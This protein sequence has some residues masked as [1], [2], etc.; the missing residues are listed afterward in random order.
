MTQRTFQ[1]YDEYSPVDQ[2]SG[3]DQCYWCCV[4]NF[5]VPVLII[6][7]RGRLDWINIRNRGVYDID[8]NTGSHYPNPETKRLVFDVVEYRG[9]IYTDY[10]YIEGSMRQLTAQDGIPK[11]D[12]YRLRV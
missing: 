2:D 11:M 7:E 5:C 6:N 8:I 10:M 12:I 1:Y 9:W 3:I 4:T